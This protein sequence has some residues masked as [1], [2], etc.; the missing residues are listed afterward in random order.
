M[1]KILILEPFYG[2]SHKQL[3]DYLEKE[4]LCPPRSA[5][6][7]DENKNGDAATP[8]VT[9][10]LVSLPAK[11]WHWRA[12]TSALYF[13]EKVAENA[14]FD[15]LF[16]SSV[17]SLAEL[18]GLRPDLARIRRKIV[19]FHEN[20]LVYPVREAKDRDFQYGYNQITTAL[21]ADEVVFNSRFNLESFLENISKHLNLQPDFRPDKDALRSRLMRKST[22]IYFPIA[23][24]Q[25]FSP[26]RDCAHISQSG[27][28][29]RPDFRSRDRGDVLRIVWPHRWEHDKNPEDFFQVLIRLKEEVGCRFQVSVLG[30]SYSEVPEIFE[31]ARNE[32]SSSPLDNDDDDPKDKA[33]DFVRHWGY[34]PTK[35]DYW[36]HLA[37]SHVVVSTAKH[38]FFGVSTLEAVV[39][40][41]FPLLPNRLVY[42]ELYPKDCL[43]NTNQ[44]LFKRL[45]NFAQRPS[46][47]PDPKKIV[48]FEKLA[49]LR[50]EYF[51]LFFPKD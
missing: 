19:Y 31:R 28:G 6:D 10:E 41:C 49:N 18:L 24:P 12:R 20:Q 1:T 42:P 13:A 43:Y 30:E 23:I 15:I 8:N 44:Q 38:E 2:G 40:G 11:K 25:E 7:D 29:A 48:N 34:L 36:R 50:A 26:F 17:L 22:V 35:A 32:L 51:N 4:V 45:K 16:C 37:E 9:F 27:N 21:A 33:F 47:V 5:G 3:I 14:D 46:S 39:A